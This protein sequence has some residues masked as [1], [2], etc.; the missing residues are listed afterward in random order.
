MGGGA[1]GRDTGDPVESERRPGLALGAGLVPAGGHGVAPALLLP[2]N[3]PLGVG[4]WLGVLV[5]VVVVDLAAR[6]SAGRVATTEEFARF[7][8]TARLANAALIAAWVFAGYHL[9]PR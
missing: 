4:F 5:A 3:R 2:S 8:S 7:I 1:Q 9:F 6:R